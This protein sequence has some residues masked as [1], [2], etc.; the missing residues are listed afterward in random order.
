MGLEV[1]LLSGHGADNIA[2]DRHPL[3]NRHAGASS[4]RGARPCQTLD[5]AAFE[6]Y[7]QSRAFHKWKYRMWNEGVKMPTQLASGKSKCFCGAKIDPT[8]TEDHISS[9]HMDLK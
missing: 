5:G 3:S 4:P 2:R 1:R 8:N 6:A 9:A 7:R